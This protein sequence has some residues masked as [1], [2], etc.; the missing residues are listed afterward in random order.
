MEE[1]EHRS[2][3]GTNLEVSPED[4]IVIPEIYAFIMDQIKNLPC[5]KIVLCQSYDYIFDICS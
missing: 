2:I 5:G 1:L 4:L 3:E